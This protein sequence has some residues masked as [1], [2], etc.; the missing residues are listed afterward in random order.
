[1]SDWDWNS[2]LWGMAVGSLAT[3]VVGATVLYFTWPYLVS[4]TVGT[5]TAK[6]L[7]EKVK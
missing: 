1:M 2:F 6:K 5:E 7:L 4:A 3:I